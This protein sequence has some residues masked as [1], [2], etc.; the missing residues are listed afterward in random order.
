MA[1]VRP[2]LTLKTLPDHRIP[3]Q[4][5]SKTTMGHPANG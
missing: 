5:F 4:L 1:V 3:I 2:S